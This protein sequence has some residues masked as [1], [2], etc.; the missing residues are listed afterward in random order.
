MLIFRKIA[1]ITL[2]IV[3]L[4]AALALPEVRTYLVDNW[5]SDIPQGWAMLVGAL[6]GLLAI[7]WQT[8]AGFRHLIESQKHNSELDR[9]AL[10]ERARLDREAREHQ[11]RLD[12]E[13]EQSKQ[14]REAK[15]LAAAL[16]GEVLACHKKYLE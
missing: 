4:A 11:A 10:L 16:R 7:A 6:I 14:K 9:K 15:V 13:A 2:P 3:A 1:L 8:R 12:L 5:P